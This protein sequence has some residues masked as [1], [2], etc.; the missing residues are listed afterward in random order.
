LPNLIDFLL[1]FSNIFI[2]NFT[3]AVGSHSYL[4]HVIR[5]GSHKAVDLPQLSLAENNDM[6]LHDHRPDEIA[7]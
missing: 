2:I 7:L 6:P 5:N 3:C 1:D 4:I